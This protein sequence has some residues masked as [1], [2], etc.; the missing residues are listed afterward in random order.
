MQTCR[1]KH[2][3]VVL[4][5]MLILGVLLI[6]PVFATADVD[7]PETDK[8]VKIVNPLKFDTLG[9][10]VEQLVTVARNIGMLVAVFSIVYAGFLKVTALGDEKKLE[11]ANKA[12]LWSVIG[13][14]VL[15]GA[16]L[17]ATAIQGTVQELEAPAGSWHNVYE[18][19]IA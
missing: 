8:S 16:W 11:K 2:K 5:G 15:L 13:T 7:P 4:L 9:K 19:W 17:I 1:G 6:M 10:F 3:V 18:T 12:F 14:A